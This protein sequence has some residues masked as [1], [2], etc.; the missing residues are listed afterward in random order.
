MYLA[1][2]AVEG[3]VLVPLQHTRV[4][5]GDDCTGQGIECLGLGVFVEVA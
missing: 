5:Q 4:K 2:A 3:N 1:G